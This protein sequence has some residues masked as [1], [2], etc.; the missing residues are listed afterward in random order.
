MLLPLS[1]AC[2]LHQS[3]TGRGFPWLPATTHAGQAGEEVRSRQKGR[4][5]LE[6]L[7]AYAP[8]LNPVEY[9]W[10]RWKI[11]EL[12]TYCPKDC[13]QLSSKALNRIHK[14]K[15]LI[16]AFWKQAEL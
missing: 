5:W 4:I 7:P 8:K 6:S 3:R 9:I 12:P 13:F 11:H 10:G 2:R 15:T 14:R 16:T 1:R